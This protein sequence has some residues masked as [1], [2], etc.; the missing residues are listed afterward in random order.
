MPNHNTRRIEN[1]IA[2]PAIPDWRRE[3]RL[4]NTHRASSW[5]NTEK[6]RMRIP[7]ATTLNAR[8]RG[9]V[10]TRTMTSKT[11]IRWLRKRRPAANEP[12]GGALSYSGIT[13]IVCL[14]GTTAARAAAESFA[15]FACS[16][17]AIVLTAAVRSESFG[18]SFCQ[19]RSMT[20]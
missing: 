20:W 15:C 18:H 9:G 11:F 13:R 19:P 3:S 10:R 7:A 2:T 8:C 14:T 5:A 6:K 12:P 17:A 1:V 16:F 4:R